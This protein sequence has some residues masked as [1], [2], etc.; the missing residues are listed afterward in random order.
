[1]VR[2]CN[3]LGMTCCSPD[4]ITLFFVTSHLISCVASVSVSPIF[5]ELRSF[6][7]KVLI[8]ENCLSQKDVLLL[9]SA[10]GSQAFTKLK[11]KRIYFLKLFVF[12]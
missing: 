12:V 3:T 7:I 2:C 1:M 11:K 6:V 4:G 9:V 8:F 10:Q 5:T